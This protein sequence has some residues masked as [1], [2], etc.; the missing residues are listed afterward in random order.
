MP[1]KIVDASVIAAYCFREPRHEEALNLING[2][3][4]HAPALLYYELT[5]VA[6]RKTNEQPGKTQ[7]FRAALGEAFSIPVQLD[8][9]DHFAVLDTADFANITTYDACY[10][11]LSIKLGAELL[12]FDKE[13]AKIARS[14]KN[15]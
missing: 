1:V 13:L 6:R 12:T 7:T 9:I 14:L 10:L 15:P 3:E 5:S 11:Y 4:L 2:A 8:D